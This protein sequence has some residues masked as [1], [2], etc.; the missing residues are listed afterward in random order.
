M[1]SFLTA[2]IKVIT[3]HLVGDYV[4]QNDFIA[5]TKG[6]NWYHMFVHCFLYTVPFWLLF[7]EFTP[8][9]IVFVTHVI[10]DLMKARWKSI[11]Y[12]TDQIIHYMV[13]STVYLVWLKGGW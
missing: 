2:W 3:C 5:K 1:I 11:G 12:V 10:V 6:E 13:A 9:A 4:L 7:H 8:L